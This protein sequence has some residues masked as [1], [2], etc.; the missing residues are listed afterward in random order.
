MTAKT[1]NLILSDRYFYDLA[2]RVYERLPRRKFALADPIVNTEFANGEIMPKIP[3]T[4]R[5]RTVYLF[6]DLFHPNPNTALIRLMLTLNALTLASV[7]KITLVIPYC[8]YER[9]D[10]KVEARTPLSIQLIARMLAL[11]GAVNR[12]LRLDLHVDQ[13]Q[14]CFSVPVDNLLG[15]LVFLPRVKGH[16]LSVVVASPDFGGA[17]RAR[18]FAR[19][20][21][22]EV[23]VVIFNKQRTGPNKAEILTV[24]GESVEG[25]HVI[26]LDDLIDTG[27]SIVAA[28]AELRRLGALSVTVLASHAVFSAKDGITAEA[29]L[30]AA[31]VKV[32]V[33][34]SIPR[35]EDYRLEH[36]DWLTI[37]PLDELFARAM[38]EMATV[39]GS[40]SSLFSA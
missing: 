37:E 10:R 27:G 15:T 9:Q 12:I 33:T 34:E 18:R 16:Y 2:R 4:V 38:S 32:V 28:N 20:L 11:S 23:G 40:V 31:G 14:N 6:A 29:R 30:K 35:G 25:K 39:G 3:E 7:E 1:P 21:G 24:I 8:P 19:Q 13:I 36:S 5:N 22:P 26:L 17:T